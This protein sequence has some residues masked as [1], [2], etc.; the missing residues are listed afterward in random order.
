[1]SPIAI[2]PSRV[3]RAISIYKFHTTADVLRLDIMHPVISGNKWFKLKNYLH[4]A[5]LLDKKVLVTYGGAFSNHIVATAAAASAK[6]LRSVGFIRGEEGRVPSPTLTEAAD[7]GMQLFYL[8]REAFRR[9]ILPDSFSRIYDPDELYFIHEGGY[10]KPGAAGAAD[11]LLEV[12]TGTYTHIIAAV[13]TGTMLAGL[14]G[15]SGPQQTVIGIP[16]LKNCVSLQQEIEAL[17]SPEKRSKFYLMHDYH[18]GGYAKYTTELLDFINELYQRTGIPTDFVYT[19]KLFFA[20]HDL[21]AKNV[22]PSGSRLLVVHS[23]GLQ[24]NRSL[25]KGTL[26]F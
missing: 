25:P 15:A 13:G 24:G 2:L 26:I 7:Y 18:F 1:M 11:I 23:G 21:V 8:S 16:V 5:V 12:D 3:D 22:F 19:G 14:V 6:G 9:K 17:V 20:V 10:G 4:E